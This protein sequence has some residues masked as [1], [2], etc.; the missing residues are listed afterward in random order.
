M[1]AATASGSVRSPCSTQHQ[2][3]VRRLGARARV[4]ARVRVRVPVRVRVRTRAGCLHHLERL[5]DHLVLLKAAQ[6]APCRAGRQHAIRRSCLC[7]DLHDASVQLQC[8][9]DERCLAR[10]GEPARAGRLPRRWHRRRHRWC[11]RRDSGT[12]A[13]WPQ[14]T[15][16]RHTTVANAQRRGRIHAAH[17]AGVQP[18]DP[19]HRHGGW[20]PSHGSSRCLFRLAGCRLLCRRR[21][22][23]H[24]RRDSRRWVGHRADSRRADAGL[25]PALLRHHHAKRRAQTSRSPR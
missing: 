17:A 4:R 8:L 1:S 25:L 2:R 3:T 6:P 11:Q 14:L 22:R 16:Q 15:V 19:A 24:A 13:S 10:G 18:F 12:A 21:A 20:E 7:D 5:P 23:H 9:C